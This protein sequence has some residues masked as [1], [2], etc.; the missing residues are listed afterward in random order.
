MTSEFDVD[1]WLE[2]Q[3]WQATLNDASPVVRAWC[4][5]F[6]RGATLNPRERREAGDEQRP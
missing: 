2:E 3:Q 5:E 1:R 6:L 4:D